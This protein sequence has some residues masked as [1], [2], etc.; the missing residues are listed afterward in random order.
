MKMKTTGQIQ[1][2]L[3]DQLDRLAPNLKLMNSA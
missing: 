1:H 3:N 2:Y